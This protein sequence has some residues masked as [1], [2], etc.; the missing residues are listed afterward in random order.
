MNKKDAGWLA[1]GLEVAALAYQKGVAKHPLGCTCDTCLV[2]DV[3]IPVTL[4]VTLS[5][6]DE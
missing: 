3:S 2:I 4:G 5:L 1:L 6:D